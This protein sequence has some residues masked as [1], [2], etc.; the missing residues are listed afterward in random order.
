MRSISAALLLLMTSG[1]PALA[2]SGGL[3]H[4]DNSWAPREFPRSSAQQN[5]DARP[6]QDYRRQ[7]GYDQDDQ[8]R[9]EGDEPQL[10]V[11]VWLEAQRDLFRPGEQT[12]ALVRPTQDSYV[13]VLHSPPD[14]DVEF[15]WPRDYNDDGFM[16]GG[17]AYAL[18]SRFTGRY[19][20]LGTGYGLG[21]VMA[22]AS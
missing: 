8:E 18:T 10:G 4:S 12:R 1:A 5:E 21:Y 6:A 7:D 17:R 19:L 15:L 2:Q 22:V 20:R 16:E 11:R 13:A 3:T 14:G 9:Q